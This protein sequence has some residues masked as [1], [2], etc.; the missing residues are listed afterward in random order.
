MD[1]QIE[2][3]IKKWVEE[4][5]KWFKYWMTVVADDYGQTEEEK[6]DVACERLRIVLTEAIREALKIYHKTY[7]QKTKEKRA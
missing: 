5:R 4:Y 7:D 3:L 6:L 1:K 2:N